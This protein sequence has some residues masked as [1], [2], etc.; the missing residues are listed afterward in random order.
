M[1]EI[2]AGC[3][4]R[5][6]HFSINETDYVVDNDQ[7]GAAPDYIMCYNSVTHIY[8]QV[9]TMTLVTVKDEN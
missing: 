7:R 9:S 4:L 3:L 6:Q 2:Y 8:R 1:K 5:G